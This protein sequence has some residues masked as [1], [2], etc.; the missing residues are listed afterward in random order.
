MIRYLPFAVSLHLY[1]AHISFSV[2][3]LP[4][5][6]LDDL[7]NGAAKKFVA[8]SSCFF[9]CSCHLF[10]C[11]FV[12]SFQFFFVSFKVRNRNGHWTKRLFLFLPLFESKE[13]DRSAMLKR[14][15]RAKERRRGDAKLRRQKPSKKK[16][17][18]KKAQT[19][20][21]KRKV[22]LN[23]KLF[24][25]ILFLSYARIS[26]LPS[27]FVY[28]TFPFWLSLPLTLDLLFFQK[29]KKTNFTCCRRDV[30]IVIV[31]NLIVLLC[32]FITCIV[33]KTD[34]VSRSSKARIYMLIS[35]SFGI[36]HFFLLLF[37]LLFLLMLFF[38]AFF[39]VYC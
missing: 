3:S 20:I 25:A 33:W 17:W 5:L 1:S 10:V 39:L 38:C 9:D 8:V 2:V 23:W 19:N 6:W 24:V 13:T 15:L 12:Y 4:S 11:L 34:A 29:K 28:L 32:F 30:I 21:N 16:R 31:F 36:Q 27:P 35:I 37:L 14:R 26:L 7:I 22:F 18:S